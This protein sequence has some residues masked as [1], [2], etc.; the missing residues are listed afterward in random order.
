MQVETSYAEAIVRKYP[1]QVAIAIAK[2]SAGKYNP[3][4]LGWTMIT[5]GDPPMMAISVAHQRHS[6]GAIRQAKAYVISFPSAAMAEEALFFGT[7]SGRDIDKLAALK[8]ATQPAKEIDCVLLAD[9][10]ANF[11]CVLEGEM[12]TGDH[13]ILAGRVVAAHMND[14]ISVRRL[15]TLGSGYD[16]GAV[17]PAE[18]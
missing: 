18:V 6:L 17:A 10:V 2:D 13:V 3:I 15:Y 11:E 12:T 9:A 16:M 7:K 14:D 4:T 8:T 5:S 1:E